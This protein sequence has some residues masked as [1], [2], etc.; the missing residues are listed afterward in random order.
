[1]SIAGPNQV[2][3]RVRWTRHVLA[4]ALLLLLTAPNAFSQSRLDWRF[5]TASDGLPESF[6]RK[7]SKGPD[8]RIWIRNGGV[9]SMSILD[10]YSV[11]LIPEPRADRV[12]EDWDLMARVHAGSNGEVWTIENHAL[13]QYKGGH[14]IVEASEKP[15]ERMIVAMPASA[16]R[17]LVLFS[18]RLSASQPSQRSW[19]AIKKSED[20]S[21]GRFSTWSQDWLAISGSPPHMAPPDSRRDPPRTTFSGPNVTRAESV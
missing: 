3:L 15:G 4:A 1:M 20:V 13:K 19:T 11:T 10:G 8:G 16:D 12:I 14:W 21:I 7:L 9:G 2:C 5:W 6:V 17:V 18:D